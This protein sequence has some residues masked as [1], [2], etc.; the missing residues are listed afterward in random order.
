VRAASQDAAVGDPRL[1]AFRF[2][3]YF[4]GKDYKQ[5]E[6]NKEERIERNA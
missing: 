4:E 1:S 2:P 3:S 5:R 6:E